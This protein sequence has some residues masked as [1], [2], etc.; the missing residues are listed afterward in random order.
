MWK[1]DTLPPLRLAAFGVV[2]GLLGSIFPGRGLGEAPNIGLFM[3]LAGVWFAIVVGYAV[4][5]WNRRSI[6]AAA[7]A[8]AATWFAWELAVNLAVQLDQRWLDPLDLSETA[9]LA[10][11]GIAA[12]TLGAFVTWAGAAAVEPALRTRD[13]AVPIT[14]VGAGFGILLAA[15]SNLD[16]PAVLFV[17]WQAAVAFVLGHGLGRRPVAAAAVAV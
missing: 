3:V 1:F 4:W 12:G 10:L 5:D 9:S 13:V 2:S 8:F 14:I 7:I 16:Y 17:P 6:I 11:S 15:S